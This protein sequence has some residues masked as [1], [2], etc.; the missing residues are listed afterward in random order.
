MNY[1]WAHPPERHEDMYVRVKP[2]WPRSRR[3]SQV[4]PPCPP[5]NCA[6][7]LFVQADG[8]RDPPLLRPQYDGPGGSAHRF[9]PRRLLHDGWHRCG[10][11]PG[12]LP[13]G[14]VDGSAW[15]AAHLHD[16]YSPGLPTT[17]GFTQL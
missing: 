7:V 16:H 8:L 4:P 14:G 10:D 1:T 13:R 11:L 17:A 5:S 2:H 3:M 15:R 6:S 9:V 12:G